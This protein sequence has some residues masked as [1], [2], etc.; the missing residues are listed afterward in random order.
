MEVSLAR[1]IG[2]LSATQLLSLKLNTWYMVFVALS[3]NAR[4]HLKVYI[5]AE[6]CD[7][8]LAQT[9]IGRVFSLT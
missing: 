2:R 6:N 8:T 1:D 3:V 9:P 7:I 4:K 5:Y